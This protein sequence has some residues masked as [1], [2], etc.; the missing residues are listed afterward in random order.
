MH[1]DGEIHTDGTVADSA[2]T[3]AVTETALTL[4]QS[5]LALI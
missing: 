3:D 1:T 2:A 4:L 5:L